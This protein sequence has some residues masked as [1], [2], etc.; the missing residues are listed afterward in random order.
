MAATS[1]V[2]EPNQKEIYSNFIDSLKSPATKKTYAHFLNVF[3]KFHHIPEGEYAALFVDPERKIKQYL[4]EASK[5]DY[6]KNHFRV[7]MA[8]L[9]NFY[10]MN[11]YDEIKWNKVK[12]FIGETKPPHVDR[13]YSHEEILTLVQSAPSLKMKAI[14]VL[15]A[16][17]GLRVSAV[18][19][20]KLSHL[21]KIGNLYKISVYEGQKGKGHY[22]TYCTPAHRHYW[23]LQKL[24]LLIR[25][26]LNLKHN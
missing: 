18:P 11:D 14:I 21:Q 2:I 12:R 10:E 1:S 20:L 4:V 8:A 3:M 17:A 13:A 16:S 6:S 19:N 15:M 23:K 7:L 5:K 9:K 22:S 25:H 26:K 24:I